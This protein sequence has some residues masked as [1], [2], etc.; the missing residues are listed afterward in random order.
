VFIVCDKVWLDFG[1][2]IGDKYSFFSLGQGEK[3]VFP[4]KNLWNGITDWLRGRLTARFLC[5][6]DNPIY[7][8]NRSSITTSLFC[9]RIQL[10]ANKKL[11][12]CP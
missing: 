3:Q 2:L 5:A 11:I 6:W 10:W 4:P 8:L 12:H 7:I 1:L 9:Q